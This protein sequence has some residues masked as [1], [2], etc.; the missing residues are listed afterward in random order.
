MLA[1][2]HRLGDGRQEGGG[3]GRLEEPDHE[4][5]CAARGEEA[6]VVI[7]GASPAV[8]LGPS[9]SA[10]LL[11]DLDGSAEVHDQSVDVLTRT[12]LPL[13]EGDTGGGDPEGEGLVDVALAVGVGGR[14]DDDERK[15]KRIPLARRE[16]DAERVVGGRLRAEVDD[17]ARQEERA[18]LRLADSVSGT[19]HGHPA[20]QRR[21][22]VVLP[23]QLIVVPQQRPIVVPQR[24]IVPQRL[25]VPRRH[26]LPE[27]GQ[28]E[29]PLVV[30][31]VSGLHPSEF[32]PRRRQCFGLLLLL[33]RRLQ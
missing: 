15:G 16:V 4:P 3:Y 17:L 13:E 23:Q 19:P 28:M 11:D 27:I 8:V 6:R 14:G 2:V 22:I 12:H 29:R 20:L 24:L 26:A 33:C 18:Q 32:E 5:R 9:T 1:A 10:R 31:V 30:V 25:L 21:L 7:F